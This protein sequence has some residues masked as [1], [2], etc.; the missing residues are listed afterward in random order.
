MAALSEHFLIGEFAGYYQELVTAK[1][2]IAEGKLAEYLG[3]G[4]REKALTDKQLIGAL[5]RH[6]KARLTQQQRYV[7]SN[8]TVFE[9]RDYLKILYA[10]CAITDEQLLFDTDWEQAGLWQSNYLL[11]HSFFGTDIAGSRFYEY[12]DEILEDRAKVSNQ[13]DLA[14]VYLISL[15]LGFKGKYRNWDSITKKPSAS[16][17]IGETDALEG[18]DADLASNFELHEDEIDANQIEHLKDKLYR[19]VETPLEQDRVFAQAYKH[20][21]YVTEDPKKHR[22]APLQKWY[23]FGLWGA[24]GYL[25]LSSIIWISL[26][27]GLGAEIKALNEIASCNQQTSSSSSS[28]QKGGSGC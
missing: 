2:A 3:I 28:N 16:E 24:L 1:R 13:S 17:A 6:L 22:I 25:V 27:S 18:L 7:R 5:F 19:V 26:T 10:A 8:A 11:E 9:Q 4:G 15:T 14:A 12:I 21:I 23:K 20:L